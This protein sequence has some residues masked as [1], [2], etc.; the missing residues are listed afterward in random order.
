MESINLDS[1]LSLSNRNIE[2]E[3]K[4]II[5]KNEE[6]YNKLNESIIMLN[7]IIEEEKENKEKLRQELNNIKDIQTMAENL[8]SKIISI[9]T[10]L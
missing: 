2:D 3:I 10:E 8:F 6:D 5:L 4:S 1:F 7:E 9:S